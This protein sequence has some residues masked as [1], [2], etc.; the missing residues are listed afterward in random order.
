MNII[1]EGY[2]AVAR[3]PHPRIGGSD[4]PTRQQDADYSWFNGFFRP[5]LDS[6]SRMSTGALDAARAAMIADPERMR[7]VA[8]AGYYLYPHDVYE[9]WD[10]I[11]RNQT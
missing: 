9:K 5:G 4:T 8:R 11:M 7:R 6:L 2:A 10:A 1:L 3:N